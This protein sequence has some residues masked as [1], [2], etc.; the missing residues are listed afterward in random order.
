MNHLYYFGDSA[1]DYEIMK[2][3]KNT[4]TLTNGV[5]SVQKIAKTILK[6]DNNSSV[7]ACLIQEILCQNKT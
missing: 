1:N 4:Y 7:I 3:I 2:Y 5:E 6:G